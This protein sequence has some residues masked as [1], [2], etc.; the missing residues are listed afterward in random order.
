MTGPQRHVR[1]AD[2]RPAPAAACRA[3]ST[4]CHASPRRR[5]HRR[6]GGINHQGHAKVAGDGWSGGPQ[7]SGCGRSSSHV[8]RAAGRRAGRTGA[9]AAAGGAAVQ[10]AGL[11]RGSLARCCRGPSRGGAL[12]QDQCLHPHPHCAVCRH[13]QGWRQARACTA[14]RGRRGSARGEVRACSAHQVG[15]GAGTSRMTPTVVSRA[16]PFRPKTRRAQTSQKPINLKCNQNGES[17]ICGQWTHP[18]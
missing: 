6:G 13:A 2:C 17:T 15:Q 4:G 9:A 11:G 7:R 18:R 12:G 10:A 16:A 1:A 3:G 8:A 5:T 14:L